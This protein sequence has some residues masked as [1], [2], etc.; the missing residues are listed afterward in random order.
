MKASL[1]KSLTL[2]HQRSRIKTPHHLPHDTLLRL[3]FSTP[4]I[5]RGIEIDD[6]MEPNPMHV[7]LVDTPASNTMFEGH[8]WGFGYMSSSISIPLPI[9]GVENA[10]L[11]PAQ[12]P[13]NLRVKRQSQVTHC[14]LSYEAVLFSSAT[15]P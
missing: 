2:L 11:M 7:S 8:A 6:D 5:G 13:D 1:T 10:S 15:V 14:V 4:P 12:Q 9:G 3:A